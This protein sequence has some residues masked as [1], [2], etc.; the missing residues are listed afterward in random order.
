METK[1]EIP[2]DLRQNEEVGNLAIS[3]MLSLKQMADAI[4]LETLGFQHCTNESQPEAEGLEAFEMYRITD[5]TEID[6]PVPVITIAGE[7]ISTEGNITTFSGASKAGKSALT[8]ICIA[9]AISEPG[10]VDGINMLTVAPNS[11]KKAVIHIDTEQARHRQQSTVCSILKRAQ[12]QTCPEYYLSY[13]IR[14]IDLCEY[15]SKTEG[16]FVA[17]D[18]VF[19]GIHLAV[20]DGLADYIK[21]VNDGEDSNAIIKFVEGLA[22]KY[23]VPIIVVVHTNPGS[24]KE[25][26]HLGSQLQRKSESV[27]SVKLDGDTSYIEPKFLRMAGKGNIPQLSFKYCPI[28]RYHVDNGVI[29]DPEERKQNAKVDSINK[30]CQAVFSG[31]A[32]FTYADA[33]KAIIAESGKR[34]SS[35]KALFK[36]MKE[37]EMI[38]QGVDKNWRLAV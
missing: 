17:A 23:R 20:I 18:K 32:A 26:G 12:F 16:I 2:F 34:E 27:I 38:L 37:E 9:G 10:M 25:R 11:K 35:A 4:D 5:K 24:D 28:K 13:N 30:I 8:A 7:I 31:Q 1:R 3:P 29:S 19:G 33:I 14:Q 6:P 15:E 22:I 36:T 21:D